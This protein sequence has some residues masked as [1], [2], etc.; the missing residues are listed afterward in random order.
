MGRGGSVMR[1]LRESVM[2]GVARLRGRRYLAGQYS[3]MHAEDSF[4]GVTW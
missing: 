2:N 3:A 4:A 1:H